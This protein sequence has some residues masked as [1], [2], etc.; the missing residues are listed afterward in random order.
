MQG[1]GAGRS[2]GSLGGGGIQGLPE[3]RN[4]TRLGMRLTR[5]SA[6]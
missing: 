6:L 2:R 4:A 5:S 1:G 3:V